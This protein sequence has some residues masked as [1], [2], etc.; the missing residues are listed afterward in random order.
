M[1]C[2]NVHSLVEVD[3]GVKTATVRTGKQPVVVDKK[4]NFL[5]NELKRFRMR[6]VCIS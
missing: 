6:A 3:G 1:G 4:I 2:W 5:V